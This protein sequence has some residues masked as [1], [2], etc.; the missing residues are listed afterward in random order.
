LTFPHYYVARDFFFTTG[1]FNISLIIP[2]LRP[3]PPLLNR[4][5]PSS[6]PSPVR[7]FQTHCRPDDP[8]PPEL[9]PV[10]SARFIPRSLSAGFF[11]C[12]SAIG[13]RPLM[14]FIFIRRHDFF[15][16]VVRRFY[17]H[18]RD[19][20]PVA[21]TPPKHISRPLA[22]SARFLRQTCPP[23]S[24]FL[25]P[26]L[27]KDLTPRTW[28]LLRQPSTTRLQVLPILPGM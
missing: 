16:I 2:H 17:L 1:S 6:L 5:L 14:P 21:I 10:L 28:F 26:P 15:M 4:S 7:G 23:K 8:S 12:F 9:P 22:P 19:T 18:S 11:R 24:L 3:S 20:P 25:S 27:S 13:S